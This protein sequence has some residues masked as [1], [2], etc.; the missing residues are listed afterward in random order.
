MLRNLYQTTV[1]PENSKKTLMSGIHTLFKVS[2]LKFCK[3]DNPPG[4]CTIK[5]STTLLFKDKH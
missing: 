5:I 2:T 4:Y 1:E 3:F